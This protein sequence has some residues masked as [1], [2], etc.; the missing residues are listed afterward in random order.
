MAIV[1]PTGSGKTTILNLALGFCAPVQGRVR[2]CGENIESLAPSDILSM[3][4]VVQ[5]RPYLFDRT[6]E[7]NLKIARPDASQD[8]IEEA[9]TLAG[10]RSF[11]DAL[12]DQYKTN[13]GENGFAL[14]GGELK[15][16]ALARA[17][18]KDAPCLILDEVGEG[19]DH[20]VEDE[21][22]SN[23]IDRLGDRS[24][25]IITHRREVAA[26]M[27]KVLHIPPSADV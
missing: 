23:M 2:L 25:I 9:C 8:Q 26:R 24:L 15:R 10:L 17:I 14:S 12:P 21:I 6:I 16:L 1:G 3:F 20:R 11:I 7:E 5:Q 19:L 22:I 18:L 4:A 13:V 27:D